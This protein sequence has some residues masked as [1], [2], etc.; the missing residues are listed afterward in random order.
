[1][2]LRER[3]PAAVALHFAGSEYAFGH[4]VGANQGDDG[5]LHVRVRQ[6]LTVTQVPTV[7]KHYEMGI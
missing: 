3:L 4:V 1:M 5:V 6:L 7:L 2:L